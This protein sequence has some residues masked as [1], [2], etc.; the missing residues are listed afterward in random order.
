MKKSTTKEDFVE[1]KSK[2]L[3]VIPY[4]ESVTEKATR[5]FR[6]HGISTAVRPHNT[7]R[8]MLVHPKDKRDPLST[9]DCVY[10]LP[11]SNCNLTYI[12]ETGRRFSTRLNEHK[13]ETEKLEASRRN[14]TRQSRNCQNSKFF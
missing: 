13:K 4:V 12:G 14:F 1:Q 7:L 6:R 10:E 11:C 2:G 8:K 9:T 3:V 5:V